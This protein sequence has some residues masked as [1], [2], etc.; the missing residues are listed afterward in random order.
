MAKAFLGVTTTVICA[1]ALV[2]C[3]G[4]DDSGAAGTGG[5]AMSRCSGGARC[6]ADGDAG[7]AAGRDAGDT[8]TGLGGSHAGTG[9][10]GA[11]GTGSVSADAGALNDT[12]S[13]D[14]WNARTPELLPIVWP[15]ARMGH[16]LAY[17][18]KREK[19]VMYGGGNSGNRFD[20]VWERD[21]AGAWSQVE[22]GAER[23]PVSRVFHGMT[24]DAAR[25]RTVVFGGQGIVAT[26]GDV[27]D[28][29]GTSGAWTV[30]ETAQGAPWPLGRNGHG[31]LFAPEVGRSIAFGGCCDWSKRDV[32]E[33]NGTDGTWTDVT[34][35][36]LPKTWP[37]GRRYHAMV[38][39]PERGVL[40][41]F[42]GAEQIPP[43]DNVA[44][45]DLWEYD[46]A[47]RTW[48]DRTPATRPAAWPSARFMHAMAYD[49]ARK[50]VVLFGGTAGGPAG[51]PYAG[52]GDLW[53]YDVADGT[54]LEVEAPDP[55]AWPVARWAHAM[56]YDQARESVVMFGGLTR[57]PVGEEHLRDTW[58]YRP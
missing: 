54:W 56:T 40:V 7:V 5:D 10:T 38:R 36:P 3:F 57:G 29:D 27:W 43:N 20:D 12:W 22:Q 41:M 4:G 1:V 16:A 14:G 51:E 39:D 42:G 11:G 21:A 15:E 19:V 26:I 53:E 31:F 9:G 44:V 13:D 46:P 55:D 52:L 25:S 24:Y 45:D 50:K 47:G 35:S 23:A 37:A 8:L 48:T 30:R 32:W 28:Y 2:G 49:A 58:E 34:P 33:W 18:S 6:V 17:D